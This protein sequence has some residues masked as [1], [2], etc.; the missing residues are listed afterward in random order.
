M[1]CLSPISR[2]GRGG[3]RATFC[4][5]IGIASICSFVTGDEELLSGKGTTREET[6]VT[7]NVKRMDEYIIGRY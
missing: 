5:T 1:M 4:C 2:I 6:R 7:I 3:D